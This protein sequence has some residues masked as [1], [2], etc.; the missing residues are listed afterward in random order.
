MDTMG[1]ADQYEYDEELPPPR[2]PWLTSEALAVTSL[3][4]AI[5]S[6]FVTGV[7]QYVVFVVTESLGVNNGSN[8]Q[9]QVVL[10]MAPVAI[11][12]FIAVASGVTALKR[13]SDDRWAGALAVA[14]LAL[15]AVILLV[16]AGSMLAVWVHDPVFS[17]AE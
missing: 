4:L 11:M 3:A 12:S 10:F 1:D 2:Q 9:K 14:G 7:S 17:P 15:G 6:L 8:Q 13:R 5:G 16:A